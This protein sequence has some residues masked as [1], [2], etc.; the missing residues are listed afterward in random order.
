MKYYIIAGEASG[1]LH[2]ANLARE[3]IRQDPRA[4][5]RGWGGD[6][7]REAGVRVTRHYKEMAIMGFLTVLKNLRRVRKNLRECAGEI[8]AWQPDAVI[9]VDYGGFNLR[10]A[11]TLAAGSARIYYYISPKVWAW[12]TS[13]VRAIKRLV[14]RMYV[15]F[16]FEVDFYRAFDYTVHYAGN[17]LV[18]A[19]HQHPR[20]EETLE[21]FAA[22]NRLP[23][24]PIIA[25]LAGSRAQE[26]RHV[27]PKM[28]RVVDQFPDFQFVIAG[29]PSMTDADYAPYLRDSPVPVV[30]GQTYR[31]L[32]HSSAALVTSGTATLETA[33]LRV[34]QVVCYSG[35]G[36]FLAYIL[37][38]LF[39][40]V[41]YI[42]LV[43][44]IAGRPIVQELL[45][46]QLTPRRLSRALSLILTPPARSR[47]LLDYDEIS[48]LLGPP[49]ASSRVASHIIQSL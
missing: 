14:D 2:A 42:S 47:L 38:K 44:L 24:K 17:P 37:F 20:E 31:L 27:L 4:D 43:N 26:I 36:G 35:E 25:L 13:R 39:V 8:R 34:P 28:L 18:D 10:L 33:L 32:R 16:P 23:A 12:N 45:M 21:A 9:L 41:R 40:K 22:D 30:H 6:L 3:L 7:M 48:R 5:L 1:D 11:R 19:I 49:G 15:I 29:A 46:Q